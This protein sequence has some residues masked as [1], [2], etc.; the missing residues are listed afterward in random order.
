MLKIQK[1]LKV[2]TI[3]NRM[4]NLKQI[5]KIMKNKEAIRIMVTA[6]KIRIKLRINKSN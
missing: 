3:H 4:R 2:K 6:F 5:S 1:E